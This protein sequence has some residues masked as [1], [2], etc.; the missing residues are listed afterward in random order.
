MSAGARGAGDL[1]GAVRAQLRGPR[2]FVTQPF[3]FLQRVLP[4]I[5]V[6]P[7]PIRNPWSRYHRRHAVPQV[8]PLQT[9]IA[10]DSYSIR[11]DRLRGRPLRYHPC[12]GAETIGSVEPFAVASK[13]ALYLPNSLVTTGANAL[14]ANSHRRDV[15]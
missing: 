7:P 5:Q 9:H 1:I 14:M 2:G 3:S 12:G 10:A 13:S 4:E 8:A 6:S 15:T 11:N